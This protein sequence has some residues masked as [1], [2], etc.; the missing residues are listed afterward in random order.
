MFLVL[1]DVISNNY[2]DQL[3]TTLFSEEFNKS[4]NPSIRRY[5]DGNVGHEYWFV[6]QGENKPFNELVIPL[7]NKISE[8]SGIVGNIS[9]ART[10]L[11][12]ISINE[13]IH[14]VIHVDMTA[15][16]L[17]FL[18]YV[19]D[20][21]GD[22]IIFN[23]KYTYGNNQFLIHGQKPEPLQKISPKKGRC[24]IFDGLFYHAAGIPKKSQR[25]VINF[26]VFLN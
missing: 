4:T 8:K 3:E 20:S 17:V 5:S 16:H 9:D 7:F 24:L 10:F 11:Q 13:R 14:D 2:Q 18:Y 21:D 26:N 12:E 22:T 1:D 23:K 6:K 19:I 15:P 25:C